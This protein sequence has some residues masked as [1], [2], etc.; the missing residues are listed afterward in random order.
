MDGF[1]ELIQRGSHR[2]DVGN[3]KEIELA[4]CVNSEV[5]GAVPANFV[6]LEEK[7]VRIN[8][9]KRVKERKK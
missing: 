2:V 5:F 6:S 8:T 7:D 3:P 1:A 4:L 9:Q